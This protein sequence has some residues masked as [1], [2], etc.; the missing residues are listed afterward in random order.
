MKKKFLTYRE[1]EEQMDRIIAK[2]VKDDF[3][4]MDKRM[5]EIYD[6]RQKN[7]KTCQPTRSLGSMPIGAALQK[8]R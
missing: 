8:F 6:Q 1:L 3:A 2:R 7:S 5:V 4:Y